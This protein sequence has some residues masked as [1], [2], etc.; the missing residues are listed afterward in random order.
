DPQ[1]ANLGWDLDIY[2]D[3]EGNSR[4][5]NFNPGNQDVAIELK[6]VEIISTSF[7]N[8]KHDVPTDTAKLILTAV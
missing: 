5:Q 7:Y 4:S 1:F 8:S 6:E 3:N 2:N